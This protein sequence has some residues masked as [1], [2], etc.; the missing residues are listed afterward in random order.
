VNLFDFL[1]VAA[2]IGA[3]FGGYR[4]GFV[5]RA[6]SWLGIALGSYLALR[7]L[8]WVL[9]SQSGVTHGR[10]FL[11]A[12][13]VL[14]GCAFVGQFLGLIAGSRLQ[15]AL[16]TDR[17]RHTDHVAG[18]FAGTTGVVVII[19][20]ISP[21]MAAAPGWPA[22]TVRAS[23]VARTIERVFPAPPDA[24]R[25][26]HSVLGEG[27]FP[28]VFNALQ[29]APDAGDPPVDTGLS[30]AVI[31][32]ATNATML[33]E[34]QACRT[35][36]DGTGWAVDS[37]HVITNAHVVAGERTTSLQRADGQRL[38][39]T[40]VAFD[41]RRDIAVLLVDNV[42]VQP[43]VLGR[44]EEAGT[45]AVFGHP[46]GGP[47]R[48]APYRIARI[49]NAIGRDLYNQ[50]DVRRS[51]AILASRLRPG[52]SGSALVSKDGTVAGV[53]FAIAPDDPTVAYAVTSSEVAAVLATAGSQP[54]STGSCLG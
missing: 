38:Q 22:R 8:P 47:L 52:D 54:V 53:A 11:I 29:P 16:P 20:L 18:A 39:A 33:V 35:I 7:I 40:V 6:F 13:G 27:G 21:L 5:T 28:E 48:L 31:A 41:P 46:G 4:L 14:I 9:R 37:R 30:D 24:L 3:G 26:L 1:I 19:W 50:S 17:A 43:L 23:L 49:V 45:G 12:S 42:G 2:A 10:L 25:A 34:G 36:Q 32:R 44:T 15:L 51:V